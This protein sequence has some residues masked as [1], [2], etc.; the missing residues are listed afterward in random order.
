V[1]FRDR[2]CLLTD[3]AT[4]RAEGR[5]IVF[6]NG[7]FDLLHAGHL[8]LLDE[9]LQLGYLIVAINSDD[10]VRRLKGTSRPYWPESHRAEVLS[11]MGY[12][13]IIFDDDFPE[14][15]VASVSPDVLVKGDDYVGQPIAGESYCG[16]IHIVNRLPDLSTSRLLT[17]INDRA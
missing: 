8:H 2:Q 4:Q 15:L 10:S 3:V 5:R 14:S 13:V 7:C 12:Q 16:R 17:A 11:R 9:A 6:T 1:I